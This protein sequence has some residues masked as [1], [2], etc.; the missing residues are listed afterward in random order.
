MVSMSPAKSAVSASDGDQQHSLW[1]ATAAPAPATAPF[2]GR[3]DA[4]VI[5]VG[6]GYTGLACALTLAQAGKPVIVLEA[7]EIGHGASG[8]NGGQ[9]IPGL[10]HDPDEL[11]ARLGRDRGEKLIRLIGAAADRVFALIAKHRIDCEAR[12]C[13][14]IQLAHSAAAAKIVIAR[15]RQWKSRHAPVELLAGERLAPL[16]G[17]AAYAC[18]WLDRRGGALQPLSYV[19]GLARA[20]IGFGARV[21]TGSAVLKITRDK[22]EWVAVTVRGEARAR[23]IVLASDAYSGSLWPEL[24]TNQVVVSSVQTATGPLPEAIR[25]TILPGGAVASDTRKLVHYF[26]L[27]HEGRFVIGGRGSVGDGVPES[28]YRE[29]RR[30]AARMYP[31]LAEVQWPY[32][33]YGRVGIT[34]DWLP[35]LAEVAP[36]IWAALGYCGRGV[37]MATAMGQVLG[38]ALNYGRVP[39]YPVAALKPIPLHALRLPIMRA[40]I[41]Y[42]R[43]LDT[44]S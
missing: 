8:R 5:V 22:Q 14:W 18:G 38:E 39:V 30:A 25:R 6:A 32:R 11:L 21:H 13:G 16:A 42:Y 26:R 12:Q 29:L 20:A 2:E 9:V 36:G 41:A 33:W 44:I 37:A 7:G 23:E 19:R 10:K 40:G 1:R 15:A 27:D 28:V 34:R 43:V 17:T 31:A 4:A 3:A 35:H 24:V